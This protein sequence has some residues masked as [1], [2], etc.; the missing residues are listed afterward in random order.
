MTTLHNSKYFKKK[1]AKEKKNTNILHD[2]VSYHKACIMLV[3]WVKWEEFKSTWRDINKILTPCA[4][5]GQ[6]HHLPPT[7][8]LPNPPSFSSFH[9]SFSKERK[10]KGREERAGLHGTYKNCSG[11]MLEHE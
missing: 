1:S 9:Y 3:Y 2:L 4:G 6:T 7:V 5:K 8:T 10:E 11:G